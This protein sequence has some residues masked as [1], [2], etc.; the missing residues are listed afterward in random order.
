MPTLLPQNVITELKNWLSDITQ[1]WMQINNGKQSGETGIDIG[2]RGLGGKAI[3][4]PIY[5]VTGGTVVGAGYYGGGGVVAIKSNINYDGINGPAS[6][7][8][9]HLNEVLA[10]VGELVSPGQLIGLS[11]GQLSGGSHPSTRQFS[12]GPHIEI[13]INAPYGKANQSIWSPLGPNVNPKGFFQALASGNTSVLGTGNGPTNTGGNSSG[14]NCGS[15]P[16]PSDYKLN[17]V[18]PQYQLAL[19]QYN[20]CV[21][22]S[23]VTDIPSAL[24]ALPQNLTSSLQ[25]AIGNAIK[26]QESNLGISGA[27]DIGWRIILIV[28]GFILMISA[29]LFIGF[30]LLDKSNIEVAGSR[31]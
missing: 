30:D 20:A 1:S 8:Y 16:N 13:G 31:V 18:D 10:R 23:T 29:L 12:G 4:N 22:A 15:P 14:G 24:A 11:G 5:S 3:N 7:Y 21:A 17:V 6:I 9:Q 28:F 2:Q 25:N 27:S 26:T 19:V